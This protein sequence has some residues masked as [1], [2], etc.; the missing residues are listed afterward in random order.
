M[1]FIPGKERAAQYESADFSRAPFTIAWEVTR[2]CAYACR[3]CRADAQPK[4]H[5]DELTTSEAIRTIDYLAEFEPSPILV[6]T[7]GDPLMRRDLFE[8]VSHAD[9]RGLRVSLTPTA[10]ALVT[11]KSMQRAQ[12]AGVRRVAFSIDAQDAELHDRFRGFSGSW[13]RTMSGIEAARGAGLP[14]QINTTVCSAN[15]GVLERI[16]E[17]CHELGVVMW[18]V[19]FLVPTGRGKT[20]QPLPPDEHDAALRWLHDYSLTAG[21]QVKATAAPMYRRVVI[22]ARREGAA[23]AAPISL[24]DGL[25]RSVGAVN[26]ARGFMFISH[27]GQVMPSGFLPVS[28]GNVRQSDPVDLYRNSP[29]FK[30]LR[31]Q[32]LLGG[33]CG[34]CDFRDVCGGSRSRAYGMTGD[35]FASDP[36]CPYEPTD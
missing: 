20:L 27:V 36:C 32:D 29:L 7:G 24:P 4:R 10:T 17:L 9:K 25:A 30:N 6:M 11:D 35:M 33:K 22:Q 23:L 5:P 12:E 2:A 31:N 1:T 3:H 34:R 8:L 21:F 13:E 16:G 26:E 19:F 15:V 28:A 18:S 14:F